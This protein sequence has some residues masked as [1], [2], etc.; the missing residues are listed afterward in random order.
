MHHNYYSKQKNNNFSLK[1]FWG[2]IKPHPL[3]PFW[4]RL[5]RWALIFGGTGFLAGII[6][7]ILSLIIFSFGLPK[8]NEDDLL[9]AQSTIIMDREGNILYAIHGEENRKIVN[10]DEISPYLLDAT[11]AI[12]DDQFY[13]H[14]GFDIPCLAKAV[15]YETFGIGIRRGCS[16]ITQQLAKNLFLNP[17]QTYKRKIQ[18]LVLA[19]KMEIFF[20][21]EDILK[22]YLN[23]IPY[24]NNAYGSELA[25]QTYFSKPAKDLT[26]TE[27][28][29]L[30]ALPKAPTR[31]SP[32]GNNRYSHLTIEFTEE[33]L[34]KRPLKSTEDLNYEE[35]VRGLIGANIS[36]ADGS[37]LYIPGRVDLVLNAMLTQGK[38]T[39]EEMEMARTES[40]SIE[41]KR[42]HGNAKAM[43]FVLYVKELLEEKYGK[44][45]I[46]QG[47]LK[48]ITTLDY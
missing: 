45:V 46:E 40:W 36:L 37:T 19:V 17:T 6:I 30:A 1:I 13:D 14:F 22:L 8:I 48:V 39:Q 2:K 21:K 16:T 29:I 25:A 42:Y 43:H 11:I 15:A 27:A 35:Y 31:Y 47:G 7:F 3:L 23:E 34:Q 41:F 4:Q 38:I 9:Q 18:E 44:E 28:S 32:Y 33:Q 12:E 20:K 5:F 10:I 24:G 26:L